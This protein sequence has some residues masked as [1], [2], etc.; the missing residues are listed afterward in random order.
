MSL[1]W[2]SN[3]HISS[4]NSIIPDLILEELKQQTNNFVL[5]SDDNNID[6]IV[7][8][9]DKTKEE[10]DLIYKQYLERSILKY[11]TEN[12]GN[13]HSDGIN[14]FI[15][16][17]KN[18]II[19][20]LYHTIDSKLV[21][22]IKIS[23]IDEI[24][25]QNIDVEDTTELYK[26]L[27][28]QCVE[29]MDRYNN[30][31]SNL[32]FFVFEYTNDSVKK[33]SVIINLMK[34][35]RNTYFVDCL[36]RDKNVESIEDFNKNVEKMILNN[37]FEKIFAAYNESLQNKQ[38]NILS[39]S[40]SKLWS[41]TSDSN[42]KK[43]PQKELDAEEEERNY[44]SLSPSQKF[45]KFN[46]FKKLAIMNL[47]RKKDNIRESNKSI[48]Q[49]KSEIDDSVIFNRYTNMQKV[50]EYHRHLFIIQQY[51][52]MFDHSITIAD[53]YTTL[54][55]FEINYEYIMFL[56]PI[57]ETVCHAGK[58]IEDFIRIYEFIIQKISNTQGTNVINGFLIDRI[59]SAYEYKNQF[60]KWNFNT[61]L[62][63]KE[64]NYALE[65]DLLSQQD[66]VVISNVCKFKFSKIASFYQ[67]T[68]FSKE[69]NK[70]QI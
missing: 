56:I 52:K 5:L 4:A 14:Y 9:K 23:N 43:T 44:E 58:Y 3:K 20:S 15:Q 54:N 19:N 36:A 8:F 62:S 25:E 34:T 21:T 27:L 17:I 32:A 39:K 57:I 30:F 24:F 40:F 10:V 41:F 59:S 50:S 45:E 48:E 38:T 1:F 53:L 65:N 47:I 35:I 70:Y 63:L 7:T 28:S 33:H 16:Q 55:E 37:Y 12:N 46:K 60:R 49:C 69:L 2:S 51:N 13:I 68:I 31:F 22:Q 11:Y 67:N 6:S 29:R 42:N 64:W 26:S 61:L 66:Q 18:P